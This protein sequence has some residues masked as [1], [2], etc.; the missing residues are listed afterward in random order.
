VIRRL[1]RRLDTGLQLYRQLIH[2]SLAA[3]LQ[4]RV[5]LLIWLIGQVLAPVIYLV[6]WSTVSVASGGSVGGYTS[7]DF[8]AYYLALMIVG[9]LTYTWI[10]YE[11]DYRVRE[12]TLSASLLRPL[13][14]IHGDIADNLG[15]KAMSAPF[16]LAVA[17]GLGLIFQPTFTFVPWAAVA[18]IPVI[19]LAFVLRFF[20]EWTL[21]QAAFW[22]T[23]VSAINQ[24]YF[25]AM[26][27]FAGEMA[28]L[29]LM[30]PPVQTIATLLPFRWMIAFP[31]ELLLGKLTPQQTLAGVAAQ[32]AWIGLSY[33]LLRVVW[34]L[35]LRQYSAVGA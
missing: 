35:G 11:Y 27:F 28:P 15:S 3:M 18:F 16:M 7:G 25:L 29:A 20:V 5:A 24:L 34:R 22:T 33:A 12:G 4:Y 13:H 8:A 30:P 17:F 31:I 23:R 21:A 1:R 19:G 6:V 14:P 10:M 9:H 26:L 32:L 2:T